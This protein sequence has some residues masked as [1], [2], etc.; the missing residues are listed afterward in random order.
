MKVEL[1]NTTRKLC[2]I[3]DP[4]MHSRSPLIQNAM[5]GELGLDYIYLCQPV[6]GGQGGRWLE[7]ATVAG[8]AGFN[9]TMPFKEELLLFMDEVEPFAQLCGAVNT[10]CI[11]DEKYYGYNTDGPG[12][13]MA[14][15]D[16]G[17]APAGKKVVLLGAGGAAKAVALAL[18]KAGA[19]V[20]VCNRN[21]ARAEEL[22]QLM[23]E[24][25]SPC[26]FTI[27]KLCKQMEEADLLVNCTSLG[28]AG[29]GTEFPD[30]SFVEALPAGAAV[31]DA[32]Y[33]PLETRLLKAARARGLRTMNGLGMLV[34]Q[35]VLALEHFAGEPIDRE[36]AKAAALEALKKEKQEE[37]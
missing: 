7:A 36:K 33:V 31:C 17:V 10:I 37:K 30:L 11:K 5:I 13:L 27:K 22:C 8:Y 15:A 32:V 3:G 2:V 23:P 35:A 12:F 25:L 20:S 16:L 24:Q 21:M 26:G 9:A 6:P 4:V 14:L 29:T 28:M 34:G 19:R 18:G 1:K